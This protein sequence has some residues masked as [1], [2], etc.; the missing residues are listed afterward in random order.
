MLEQ[1]IMS[2]WLVRGS[3]CAKRLV[4]HDIYH[5]L[6][7]NA[8]PTVPLNCM[9]PLFDASVTSWS[10]DGKAEDLATVNLGPPPNVLIWT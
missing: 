4:S 8:M 2:R 10:V 7:N 5:A 3:F 6:Y 9:S 1:V